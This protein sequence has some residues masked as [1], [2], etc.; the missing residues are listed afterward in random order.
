[1][2]N[3]YTS[4]YLNQSGGGLIGHIYKSPN[5]RIQRGRGLGS[6]FGGLMRFL[7]PLLKSGINAVKDQAIKSG[8]GVLQDIAANK[9]PLKGIL[10]QRGMEARDNLRDRAMKKIQ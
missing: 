1:M 10:L 3:P 5:T 4:Y 2:S 9:K 8:I 7:R 6:I